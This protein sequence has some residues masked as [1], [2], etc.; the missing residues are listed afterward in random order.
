MK[1]LITHYEISAM[2]FLMILI[3]GWGVLGNNL[4]KTPLLLLL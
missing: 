1:R 4:N 2:I 3:S